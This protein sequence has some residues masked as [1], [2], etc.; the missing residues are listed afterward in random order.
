MR[1]NTYLER[2]NNLMAGNTLLKLAVVLLGVGL[3]ANA[4]ITYDVTR[5]ARTIVVPPVVNTTFE[6]SGYR[7]SDD[8]ARLMTRYIMDLATNYTPATARRNFDELL[9]LYD[10]D[11]YGDGKKA[12]Y[13]LA[14]TVET[15]H[16]TGS[17]FIERMTLDE[18]KRQILVE[19]QKRLT[20]NEQRVEE[21][22]ETY[23]IDYAN[24]NGRFAI[25]NL[26]RKQTG[27]TR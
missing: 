17:F 6:L 3:V 19:G 5:R 8:Y 27:M 2:R 11:A 7:I 26:S 14:D 21:G 15:A 20:A 12:F 16:V 22:P 4:F 9:V 10:P 24:N 1:L 13:G 25:R 18:D 23:I